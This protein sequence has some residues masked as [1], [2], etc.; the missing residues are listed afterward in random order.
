MLS[1]TDAFISIV[2]P[3]FNEEEVLGALLERLRPALEQMGHDFEVI[4]VDDGSRDGSLAILT[5]LANSDSRI[6]LLSFCRNFGHQAAITAG[7]DFANGD[8][9]IM[10]DADL[11]DPP[12]II[13][14]MVALFHQGYD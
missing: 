11:Q 10:M 8:A 5:A 6:K 7:L 12:E 1:N 3:I 9:V 13:P 4:F 2:I 14:E